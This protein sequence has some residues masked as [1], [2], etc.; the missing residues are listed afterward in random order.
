MRPL[1]LSG[2]VGAS[3]TIGAGVL[4]RKQTDQTG[5]LR[6]RFLRINVAHIPRPRRLAADGS[7]TV[8]TRTAS[9][10]RS[11]GTVFVVRSV[12]VSRVEAVVAVW[13]KVSSYQVFA[14]GGTGEEAKVEP[15]SART[16]A[17]VLT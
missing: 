3:C 13:L 6:L 5:V 9:T 17:V 10:N 16:A 1:W 7:G 2:S 15:K 12:I 11:L 14:A 4:S 8:V